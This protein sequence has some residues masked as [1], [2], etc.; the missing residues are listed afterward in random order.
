MSI[1]SQ[2]RRRMV[3]LLPQG[4]RGGSLLSLPGGRRSFFTSPQGDIRAISFL[5]LGDLRVCP[6]GVRNTKT[7]LSLVPPR[8]QKIVLLVPRGERLI[9]PCPSRGH[10]Q[11]ITVPPR[12]Q[13]I[14]L[15]VPRGERM[16]CLHLPPGEKK[17]GIPPPAG[18][19]R[20]I[21]IVPPRG[22]TRRSQSLPGGTSSSFNGPLGDCASG[23]SFHQGNCLYA[24][25]HHP[26]IGLLHRGRETNRPLHHPPPIGGGN[27]KTPLSLVPPRGA[28][29]LG[30]KE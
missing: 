26:Q 19:Q 15:L 20:R 21:V 23:V 5:P 8:G 28:F 2:G 29:R 11:R 17:D 1:P 7:P 27:T 6:T 4:D 24:L 9:E 12:G 18:G 16:L 30:P 3:F 22:H 25:H 13:K 14:V 10:T